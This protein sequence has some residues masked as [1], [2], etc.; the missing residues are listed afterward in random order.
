MDQV[1]SHFVSGIDYLLRAHS[2]DIILGVLYVNVFNTIDMQPLTNLMESF[3]YVQIIN[4]PTFISGS[5][6][7]HVYVKQS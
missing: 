5:L 7:D 6:L 2:I 4:E 3:N 1:F